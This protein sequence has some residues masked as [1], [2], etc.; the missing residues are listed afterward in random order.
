MLKENG[1]TVSPP[2]QKLDAELRKIGATMVDEWLSEAGASGKS[3]VDAYKA[4]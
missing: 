1:M 4:M 2:S 3:V